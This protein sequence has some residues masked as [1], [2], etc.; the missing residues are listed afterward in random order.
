MI[1]G[2]ED[3]ENSG[4]LVQSKQRSMEN[5]VHGIEQPFEMVVEPPHSQHSSG[6]A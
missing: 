2:T 3:S 6:E 5:L 4:E 1:K